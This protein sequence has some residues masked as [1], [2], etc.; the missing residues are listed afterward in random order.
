MY[1]DM[2]VPPDMGFGVV[3]KGDMLLLHHQLLRGN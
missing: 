2:Y 1:P 3:E